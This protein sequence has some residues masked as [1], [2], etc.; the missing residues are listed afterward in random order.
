MSQL[1]TL[2]PDIKKLLQDLTEGKQLVI[3]PEELD[4]TMANLRESLVHWGTPQDRSGFRLRMSNL[5]KPLRQLWYEAHSETPRSPPA[6]WTQLK[7]LYGHM[8]EQIVLMF[9]RL[10]GHNVEQEQ[11][12]V[13]VDGIKGHLDSVIDGEVVD[14]K[15]A[16]QF[17]FRKFTN[18]TLVDDDP[19]GY[20][21]QL[22][23]YEEALGSEKGGFLVINKES[24]EICLDRPDD[25]D[26]VNV[27]ERIN[28]IREALKLDTPPER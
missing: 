8:L 10:A 20:L 16:S 12:E 25:L 21:A 19:F 3:P 13:D 1:D 11:L 7:F 24:G 5:G 23:G 4:R 2:V 22:S 26:K 28:L 18:G 6:A 15:T 17:A 14:V 9:V 27:P